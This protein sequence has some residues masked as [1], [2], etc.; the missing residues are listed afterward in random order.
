VLYKSGAGEGFAVLT[1]FL[2]QA[3][4]PTVVALVGVVMLTGRARLLAVPAVV[5]AI[6]SIDTL[7]SAN[8][9][10]RFF[11][12]VWPLIALLAAVTVGY[13]VRMLAE[14]RGAVWG[15]ALAAAGGLVVLALPPGDVVSVHGTQQRYMD[16]RVGAREAAIDWLR[17][18]PPETSFAISDAG[19]VPARA[20]GR[21]VVDN[22]FLNEPLIQETGRI[23]FRQRAD[24]VHQRS[25]DVLVL[26]S[27]DAGRFVGYYPTEQA[28]YDHPAMSEYRL[29]HVA[30][31]RGAGCGYHLM[32][33]RR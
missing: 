20:E 12:P 21:F 26:S 13:G 24:L 4:L 3:W 15:V 29:A 19:L 16:C 22:F 27:R 1:K 2:D 28:I 23:P 8:A 5:Y 25:P 14:R 11:M 7:D 17:R 9:Y 6:G 33:F 32:L 10:S 18:T 31:G 30:S